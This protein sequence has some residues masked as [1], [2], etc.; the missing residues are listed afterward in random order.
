MFLSGPLKLRILRHNCYQICW[1]Q[2]R[3]YLPEI[4]L[5]HI[6]GVMA[7]QNKEFQAVDNYPRRIVF[8]RWFL[9]IVEAGLAVYFVLGF[10]LY[11]GIAFLAYGVVSLFLIF[12]LI[13]CVRCRYYGQRCNFGWGKFWVARFFP[14]D[15][16]NP[17]D[18][19][20]GWSILFLP[21]RLIPIGLG[22]RNLPLWIISGKFSFTLHGLFLIYL[23]IIIIHRQ[24]YR[25]R[26]CSKCHQREICPVFAG[27]IALPEKA[28]WMR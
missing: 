6:I 13:R 20:H 3:D 4:V 28:E 17:Y 15:D 23:A 8:L 11:L 2:S 19:Y 10:H 14:K 16:K 1:A 24:F 27:H 26:A 21:L 25:A 22:V 12:P 7:D 18:I 9:L 5:D